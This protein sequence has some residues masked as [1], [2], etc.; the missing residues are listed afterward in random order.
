MLPKV[1]NQTVERVAQWMLEQNK[2]LFF[3]ELPEHLLGT[4]IASRVIDVIAKGKRFETLTRYAQRLGPD[5]RLHRTRSVHV[6]NIAQENRG[7]RVAVR[8]TLK[9]KDERKIVV[10]YESM[11]AAEKDGFIAVSIGLC[12]RGKQATH[13]GYTWEAV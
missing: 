6:L 5:G 8:G 10:E 13:I 4:E 11:S 2:P 9:T 3:W 1:R 7:V 12:L